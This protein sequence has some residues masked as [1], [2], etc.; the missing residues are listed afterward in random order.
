MLQQWKPAVIISDIGLPGED[1]YQLVQR[2]RALKPQQGGSIPAVALTG[3]ASPI[4]ESKAR[5]AGY[6]AHLSKPVELDQLVATIARLAG[7]K[8]TRIRV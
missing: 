5:A 3:Y 7:R 4:D 6:Q 2:V 1:G 8:L